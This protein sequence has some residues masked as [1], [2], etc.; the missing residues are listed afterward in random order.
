MR[1]RADVVI[2][3]FRGLNYQDLDSDLLWRMRTKRE[4]RVLPL[5]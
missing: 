1:E 5:G 3:T 4:A 2:K